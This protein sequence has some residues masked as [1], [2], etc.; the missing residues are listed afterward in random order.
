MR[1][2]R[3]GLFGVK[4]DGSRMLV[5]QYECE[6]CVKAGAEHE[7]VSV[8]H[9]VTGRDSTWGKGVRTNRRE[10]TRCK[11]WDGPWVSADSVGGGW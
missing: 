10:C 11:R 6:H 5:N 9:G 3:S 1:S 8:R 4:M 7:V 2:K